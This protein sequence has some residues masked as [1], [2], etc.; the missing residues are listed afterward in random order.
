M[1]GAQNYTQIDHNKI[2]SQYTIRTTAHSISMVILLDVIWTAYAMWII[3]FYTISPYNLFTSIR[4]DQWSNRFGFM[5]ITE[6]IYQFEYS[7]E[8][9]NN[10]LLTSTIRLRL[11]G[12]VSLKAKCRGKIVYMVRYNTCTSYT[13]AITISRLYSFC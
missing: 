11:N 10:F 6:H 12:R 2:K 3:T 4:F 7:S 5:S 13:H 1:Y 9:N 8:T